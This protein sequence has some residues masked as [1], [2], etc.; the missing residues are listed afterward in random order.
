VVVGELLLVPT[1]E[2]GPPS[3]RSTLHALSL[4][5]GS[6]LWQKSFEYALV[7]GL[8]DV[9]TSEVSEISE[10][11]ALIATS[12]TDLMRSEGALLALDAAG[13]QRWRWAPGV[14]RVS[15]PAVARGVACVT[16]DVR[17]FLTLDLAT[18]EERAKVALEASASL[19]A[20]ALV[21]DVAYISCRG[22]HLLAV[23]LDGHS[24]WRFDAEASPD[25]WLDKTPVVVGEHLFAVL[26]TGAVLALRAEDRS[27][28]WRVDV[29]PAGKRLSTPV[30]DGE[31]L[32][33]GAR[34]GLHALDLTDGHEVW[35]F[36]TER[37][38]EAAPA[39]VGG[40][41]YA[42]CYDHHLYAF[43]AATG[44]E[45]WR[46]EVGRR[47][48][49]PP[50]MATCGEPSTPCILVTDRGGT[51][52]AIARPLS[53]E[54]VAADAGPEMAADPGE[55]MA[56]PRQP[57]R[58]DRLPPTI[59]VSPAIRQLTNLIRARHE[60]G[61]RPYTLLL[62]SSLSLTPEIRQAVCDSDDWEAFWTAMGRLSP[63]ECRA[64]LAGP[65]GALNLTAGYRCL[66]QL[67]Q[68]S[69][70]DLVLTLNVDDALDE[71]LR[72]LS[73]RE[74]QIFTH[75][76]VLGAE[77]AAALGR[78]HPRVKAVKLRGGIN[79][80]KLP[81][82]PEGQFE[83]PK[84]LEEVVEQ[85]LSQSTILVGDISSD[86][87]I[88][89]CIP[90]GDSALWVVVPEE[91]RPGSFVYNAKRA[92]PKGEVISGPDAEFV[93]FFSALARELGEAAVRA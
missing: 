90:G 80:Y 2:P 70:F 8:A 21:G 3:Q 88:Q 59:P 72:I 26:S 49:V 61:E 65:L 47:I 20:P 28:A 73:A 10:V 87:D 41:V 56:I 9:Q 55:P 57:P 86:N 44:Q 22:P 25:A 66:A 7:S 37:R 11:L 79:A 40:V 15:A 93:S 68:A 35:A 4:A 84:E 51:L 82:T 89:R 54:E 67:V 50:V 13:E 24:R 12:S 74:Y 31:R 19:S 5:D 17:T 78:T 77:I 52:V 45:L 91:P 34:D 76:Q 48:E 71:S 85:L 43:D 92:R 81:L 69:Y 62:G 16:A 46:Y 39:M 75:G 23:G 36:S 42:T 32:Y 30:T 83:F 53:A 58:A 6:P 1:Q 14:Q 18:G 64:L 38:I 29:G 63:G 27:L 33:I 60:A